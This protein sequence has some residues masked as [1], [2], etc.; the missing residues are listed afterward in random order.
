[1][2]GRTT[3]GLLIACIL[4]IG[5]SFVPVKAQSKP[6]LEYQVKAAFLFNFTRFIHWPPTAYAT[7]DAP[8]VIG[9]MGNDP[10]GTYLDDLVNEER[11]DGHRIVV[12]R[13]TDGQD[14]SDC[15]LLFISTNDA[16]KLQACLAATV[17]QNILT[18]GDA[19]NFIKLGGILRFY[20]D[21]NKIKME[22]RLAGAKAAQLDI[23]A[24][25]LQV[26]KLK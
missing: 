4:C 6:L 16:G 2:R 24:K 17:H 11:V 25:L 14:L 21:D 19:D 22:I 3:Y 5:G 12:R 10:F 9:I 23:S 7:G 8:F 15:Q 20:K 26:A 13:Y 18:V 1:M